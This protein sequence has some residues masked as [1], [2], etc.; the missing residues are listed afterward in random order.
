MDEAASDLEGCRE[1]GLKLIAQGKVACLILAGGDAS[2]LGANIPKGMFDP[3]IDGIGSIFELITKKLKRLSQLSK[4]TYPEIK[5]LER[6]NIVLCV[7][8][9]LENNRILLNSSKKTTTSDTRQWP[10][11]PKLICQSST[12]M[13]RS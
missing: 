5:A 8:T 12:L 13:D 11:S 7:M 10:S 4:E 9:N 1:E 2:R 3:R 6:D